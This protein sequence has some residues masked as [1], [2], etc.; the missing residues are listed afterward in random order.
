MKDFKGNKPF[1]NNSKN[2]RP[3]VASKGHRKF[4][5]PEKQFVPHH[6]RRH[7]DDYDDFDDEEEDYGKFKNFE[8]QYYSTNNVKVEDENNA[9]KL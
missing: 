1:G 4:D 7:D 8:L 3:L 9:M 2:N 5:K 6:F